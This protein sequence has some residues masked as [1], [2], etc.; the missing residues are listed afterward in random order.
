MTADHP[1]LCWY[2]R[3]YRFMDMF[4]DTALVRQIQRELDDI[5]QQGVRNITRL[6]RATDPTITDPLQ[7]QSSN[8]ASSNYLTGNRGRRAQRGSGE[9]MDSSLASRLVR[10]GLLTPDLLRQLQREWSKDQKQ[11]FTNQSALDT[12]HHNN[13]NKGKRRKKKWRGKTVTLWLFPWRSITD[14]QFNFTDQTVLTLLGLS[15]EEIDRLSLI[16]VGNV[17]FCWSY[18]W[19]TVLTCKLRRNIVFHSNVSVKSCTVSKI[20]LTEIFLWLCDT[21]Y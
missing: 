21:V 4:P 16:S 5:I 8:A 9:M 18:H 1:N 2:L 14:N 20:L 3:S 6:I 17:M 19:A 11:G 15:L 12:E 10:D 7:T 13:N